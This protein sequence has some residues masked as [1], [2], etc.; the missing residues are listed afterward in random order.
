MMCIIHGRGAILPQLHLTGG[1]V[2]QGFQYKKHK[3][4]GSMQFQSVLF[5][6]MQPKLQALLQHKTACMARHA[7]I[8][9]A[10]TG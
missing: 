3:E 8:Q 9:A 5:A 2:V 10:H 1:A 6:C 7:A 4:R